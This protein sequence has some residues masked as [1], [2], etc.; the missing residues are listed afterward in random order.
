MEHN[1]ELYNNNE[2]EQS[3]N[4][5]ELLEFIWRLKWWV[6]ASAFLMICLAFVYVRMQT[7]VYE[8]TSWIM[9]NKN[10]GNNAELNLMAE[11]TG[12]ATTKKIDNELFIIKSPTMMSKVVKE[13]GIN[14]RYYQY[15]MPFADNFKLGRSLFSLKKVEY[16]NNSPFEFIIER[17]PLY[18]DDMQPGSIYLEFKNLKGT[19]YQIKEFKV[20]GK[21]FESD[22]KNYSYGDSIPMGA[23]SLVL[24]LTKNAIDI[25]DGGKFV[26]TWNTPISTARGLVNRL[27]AT[28]QGKGANQSDVIILTMKDNLPKRA[29]DILNTLV[30]IVN[31]ESRDYKN[32]STQNTIA[33]IDQRLDVISS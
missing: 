16:Y 7:P 25:E 30:R 3:L 32:L 6:V 33:F 31:Q 5:R 29:A 14:A 17:N 24:N 27:N 20:N 11:F 4:I 21:D 13:L 9:M 28:V 10:D 19:H 18:P 8:R 12:R 26:C 2:E 23:F 22:T 15:K 1:T